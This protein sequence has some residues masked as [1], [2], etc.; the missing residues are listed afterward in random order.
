MVKCEICGIDFEPKNKYRP[1]RTCSKSC[2][3]KLA[4]MNSIEQFSDPANRQVMRD[5]A[6]SQKN[7]P[8]YQKKFNDGIVAREKLW[9][10]KNYHPRK[11]K[12]HTEETKRKIG[13]ANSDTFKGMT[14][15]EIYGEEVAARRRQENSESMTR[16]N[17]ELLFDK[18]SGYENQIFEYLEPLG[19]ERNKQISKYNVD[20]IH[21]ESMT[22]IE[23]HGD[24][25]HMN[26]ALYE[27]DFINTVTNIVA[28][29]KWAYDEY[30]K[31]EL[32]DM[33][34]DVIVWWE[35]DLIKNRFVEEDAIKAAIADYKGKQTQEGSVGVFDPNA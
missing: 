22:I 26:P 31:A 9:K 28:K 35:N 13:E 2:K 21:S 24:F 1:A 25:W 5:I 12:L 8:E 6:L 4:S 27:E 10:S 18:K 32:E 20:F 34:Y 3:N 11:G 19:F 15:E 23:F 17:E 33:G 30:R 16:I 14:W 7:N 29:D